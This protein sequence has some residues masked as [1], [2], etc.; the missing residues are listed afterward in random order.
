MGILWVFVGVFRVCVGVFRV[1]V[2]IFSGISVGICAGIF[3]NRSSRHQRSMFLT[4]EIIKGE[5]S[6]SKVNVSDR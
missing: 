3:I 1:V 2:G 6:A 4:V 5:Q